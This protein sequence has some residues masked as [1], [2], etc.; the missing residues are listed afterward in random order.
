MRQGHG[1]VHDA[2]VVCRVAVVKL[3]RLRHGRRPQAP[4]PRSRNSSSRCRRPCS[5]TRP[6]PPRRR[7][8]PAVAPSIE[9]LGRGAGATLETAPQACRGRGREGEERAHGDADAPDG[10]ELQARRL[11]GGHPLKCVVPQPLDVDEQRVEE[12]GRVALG[13]ERV[14]IEVADGHAHDAG[15]D[16]AGNKAEEIGRRRNEQRKKRVPVENVADDDVDFSETGLVFIVISSQNVPRVPL[17][18]FSSTYNDESA[19]EG[20]RRRVRGRHNI[21]HEAR[22]QADDDDEP[23]ELH[24][25]HDG[26]G[27]AQGP[28]SWRCHHCGNGCRRAE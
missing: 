9:I 10:L 13:G 16:D 6:D 20:R 7:R 28:E 17:V 24:G 12:D 1:H 22:A 18:L 19:D 2:Q 14:A 11:A 27:E 26:K 8:P 25:P 3:A 15:N 23:D 21:G 5:F 4:G